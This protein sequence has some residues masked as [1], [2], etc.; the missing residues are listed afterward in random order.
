MIR[1][2]MWSVEGNGFHLEVVIAFDEAF[3]FL[4]PFN[5]QVLN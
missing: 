2:R 4:A 1:L 3:K 5:D